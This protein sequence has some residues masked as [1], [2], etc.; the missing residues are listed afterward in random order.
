MES[1][2]KTSLTERSCP[3]QDSA[4]LSTT[5]SG[6]GK[7][8]LLPLLCP[9]PGPLSFDTSL[10]K[11]QGKNSH[12]PYNK[13]FSTNPQYGRKL[14]LNFPR[15]A[16]ESHIWEYS[17]NLGVPKWVCVRVCVCEKDWGGKKNSYLGTWYEIE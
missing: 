3:V 13:H 11:H 10:G 17:M 7:Q 5:L 1:H 4:Y 16:L 12:G 14:L 8:S 9:H 15:E 2:R 6:T